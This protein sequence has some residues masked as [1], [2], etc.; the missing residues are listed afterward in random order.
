M[1]SDIKQVPFTADGHPEENQLLLALE[2]EL[3][4]EEAA[5]I[6]AHLGE[7]WSCRA[8]SEEIQRGILAFVEYREQRYLPSLETPPN[9]FRLFP[10]ELR[11]VAAE[12]GRNLLIAK[13]NDYISAV[14]NLPRQI[15]WAGA[16]A[17]VMAFVIFWTQ[18]LFNPAA[19]SAQEFL[20]RA[21]RTQNPVPVTGQEPTARKPK[22]VTHQ[23]VRIRSANSSLIRDFQWTAGDPIP[24]S[25]W[26][27][28]SDLSSWN[29]PLTAA[30][31]AEWR[32]SVSVKQDKVKHSGDF[33]ILDTIAETGPIREASLS[34]RAKDF[35]PVEEHIRFADDRRLDLTE[36]AF[37]IEDQLEVVAQ[38]GAPAAGTQSSGAAPIRAAATPR[39]LNLEETE[40]QVRY[41]IFTQKWNLGEDLVIAPSSEGVTVSGIASTAE[42]A[43]SMHNFL[44]RIPNVK[45]LVNAPEPGVSRATSSALKNQRVPSMPLLKG[46]LEGAFPSSIERAEVVDRYLRVSDNELSHAWALRRLADRYKGPSED[47]LMPESRVMLKEML[48]AHLRDLAQAN[49]GL[50]S[51]VDLLPASIPPRMEVPSDW[52]TVSLA[53]F[54]QVRDQDSLVANL[55]AGT[56]ANT[57]D[58]PSASAALRS[59]HQAINMLLTGLRKDSGAKTPR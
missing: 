4:P 31:F 30:G 57:L 21:A 2:N 41:T 53:L 51:L 16:V 42:R 50:D 18:V 37:H 28:A 13:I 1:N 26:D 10:G 6:R 25:R 45:V 14:L 22:R 17:T 11:R 33:L 19:V 24:G 59:A 49:A 9:D 55:V 43:E 8:R 27:I 32:A 29:S 52:W 48:Q 39:E 15:R 23:K 40:F 20:E 56:Q 44:A 3:S 46:A 35:H 5:K 36:L 38:N 7:C 54:E 34:V 47:R 58:L 12:S